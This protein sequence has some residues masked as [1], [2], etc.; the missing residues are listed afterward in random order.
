MS[1]TTF[2]DHDPEDAY[3]ATDPISVRLDVLERVVAALNVDDDRFDA[4]RGDLLRLLD[5]LD[6]E[7]MG[8]REARRLRKLREA[9]EDL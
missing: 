1:D 8:R 7:D 5:A 9:A 2:R 4:R 6:G 3:D